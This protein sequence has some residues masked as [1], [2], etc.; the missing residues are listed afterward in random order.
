MTIVPIWYVP[1]CIVCHSSAAEVMT[2][3]QPPRLHIGGL[4][5]FRSLLM[6]RC[7]NSPAS[8]A[9]IT[10]AYLSAPKIISMALI[11][12][13]VPTGVII[14]QLSASPLTHSGFILVFNMRLSCNRCSIPLIYHHSPAQN[15]PHLLFKAD[16]VPSHKHTDIQPGLRRRVSFWTSLSI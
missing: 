9:P 4:A 3:H 10:A 16:H 12:T 11:C 6:S 14:G 5:C 15:K 8:L 13:L 2:P 1:F 7:S